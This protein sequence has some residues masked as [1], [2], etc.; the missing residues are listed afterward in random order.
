MHQ[1]LR[2]IGFHQLKNRE[3]LDSLLDE[4]I[5][6]PDTEK[7]AQD[8][9]GDEVVE[10]TREFGNGIGICVCG[11]FVGEDSLNVDYYFPYYIGSGISSEE[12]IDVER[13][14]RNESY[15][16]IC[17][18]L[19]LGIA[20]IFYLQNVNEYLHRREQSE[21]CLNHATLTLSGLSIDGKIIMPISKENKKAE[22]SAQIQQHS[23]LIAA[24]REGDEDAIESLTM[25]DIDTYSML[26]RRIMDE[27]VLSIVETSFMPCGVE[28]DLYSI[29][30][31]II[32]YTMFPNSKTME[33]LYVLK[34]NTN[35]VVFDIIINQ[36]DLLGEPAV[37]R[38]FKGD[39]WLQGRINFID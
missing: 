10:L 12:Q 16:G 11:R 8:S 18:D 20:M 37:G 34:V 29:I 5:D 26:S 24:A 32:E 22:T 17:D 39:I 38:R 9:Y 19:K 13:H 6:H 33:E 2:A 36:K 35:D 3:Q 14:A 30:G 27:D 31:E 23:N 7:Y 1:Y 15:A 21:F 4:V 25:E 28:S